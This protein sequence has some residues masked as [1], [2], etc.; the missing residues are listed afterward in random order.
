MESWRKFKEAKNDFPSDG[1]K[2]I[3]PSNYDTHQ[4][5]ASS[6]PPQGAPIKN[7]RQISIYPEPGTLFDSSTGEINLPA[8][9][10]LLDMLDQDRDMMMSD[11]DPYVDDWLERTSSRFQE[12]IE[13]LQQKGREEQSALEASLE[14]KFKS[15]ISQIHAVIAA[16]GEDTLDITDPNVNVQTITSPVPNM[17]DGSETPD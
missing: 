13:A 15:A 14:E 2:P 5:G 3:S 9:R 4:G 6:G 17:F 8:A 16:R 1:M 11:K 7:R 10:E 12:A